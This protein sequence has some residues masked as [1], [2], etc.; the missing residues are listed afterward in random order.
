M[1]KIKITK[2]IEFLMNTFKTSNVSLDKTEIEDDTLYYYFRV[3][4]KVVELRIVDDVYY[5]LTL[6]RVENKS[7]IYV[8]SVSDTNIT[9]VK[10]KFARAIAG[11][12]TVKDKVLI[13]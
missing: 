7:L 13:L 2:M 10:R 6:F 5:T 12:D 8:F 9:R 11:D 1:R 4:D 3:D